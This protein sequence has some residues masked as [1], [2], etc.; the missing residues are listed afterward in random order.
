MLLLGPLY[1]LTE[2]HERV[3]ALAEARRV[4]RVGGVVLAAGISRFASLMEGIKNG[5]LSDPAF[6]RIVAEDVRTG[7][8]RNQTGRHDYFTTAFFHHPDE[9]A[10]EARDAGLAVEEMLAIEGPLWLLKDAGAWWTDLE[11]RE[12]LL[13]LLPAVERDPALLGS[14]AHIMLI[15]RRTA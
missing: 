13:A 1:H 7:Q 3:R 10:A 9:L 15:A 4:L 6:R 2:R 14:S 12:Q 5:L 11:L 8:H